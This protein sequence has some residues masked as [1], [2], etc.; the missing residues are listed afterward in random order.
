[1][2]PKGKKSGKLEKGKKG[3]GREDEDKDETAQADGT[4]LRWQST[5]NSNLVGLLSDC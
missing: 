1:M 5:P 4:F 2:P 3:R